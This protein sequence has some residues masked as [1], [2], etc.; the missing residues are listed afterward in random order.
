MPKRL[1]R[2]LGPCGCCPWM[3]PCSICGS[4]PPSC[5]KTTLQSLTNTRRG[6]NPTCDSACDLS[7]FVGVVWHHYW[8]DFLGS[9][10]PPGCAPGVAYHNEAI[11]YIKHTQLPLPAGVCNLSDFH[12]PG[13]GNYSAPTLGSGEDFYFSNSVSATPRCQ[14]N[15]VH[16]SVSF[17][18]ARG[19][20]AVFACDEAINTGAHGDSLTPGGTLVGSTTVCTGT[21]FVRRDFTL[22]Y[23][24][25]DGTGTWSVVANFR[26]EPCPIGMVGNK[27]TLSRGIKPTRNRK[28]PCRMLLHPPVEYCTIP[29]PS[30]R[31]WHDVHAC[32]CPC[33]SHGHEKDGD[34][35]VTRARDCETCKHYVEST[36]PSES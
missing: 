31:V 7:V 19:P 2:D 16:L 29:N 23:S 24:T 34:R 33:R 18:T 5:L 8:N 13:C 9:Y 26:V 22:T 28:V 1:V 35:L 21:T 20:G 15:D 30:D 3:G 11:Q 36:A 12:S 14:S 32:D 4:K 6:I 10:G 27:P 17:G 25:T